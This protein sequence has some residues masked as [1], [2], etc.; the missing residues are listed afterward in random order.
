MS[1]PSISKPLVAIACGGTGGHLFP[2]PEGWQ[3][4]AG[5][6]SASEDPR[7]NR[8][9]NSTPEGSKSLHAQFA[10]SCTPPGCERF[11]TQHRGYRS[12]R[13]AQPP[14]TFYHPFGMNRCTTTQLRGNALIHIL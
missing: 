1:I 11:S 12:L 9:N 3:K 4:V 2:S 6:R 8:E 14:A 13:I 10:D 7:K 5:G